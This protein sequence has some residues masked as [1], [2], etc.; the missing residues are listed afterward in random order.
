IDLPEKD[1]I[2]LGRSHENITVDIDLE[3]YQASKYGVSRRHAR[4]IH[5]GN[6]W[7]LE[8]LH[9]LNGT[10]V[11][12]RQVKYGEPVTLQDQDLVRLSHLVFMFEVS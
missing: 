10:F 9:S 6:D 8:D 2:T 3:P 1:V 12:E 7:L 11:N 4:L 5:R